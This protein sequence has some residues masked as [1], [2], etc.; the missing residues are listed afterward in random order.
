MASGSLNK[1]S[2]P[3]FGRPQ[4]LEIV[5]AHRALSSRVADITAPQRH[6][7]DVFCRPQGIQPNLTLPL[8]AIQRCLQYRDGAALQDCL[9]V[10]PEALMGVRVEPL[11]DT[12]T[13]PGCVCR[14]A[15][16][17][18]ALVSIDYNGDIV[19]ALEEGGGRK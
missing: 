13:D 4:P 3:L 17:E 2:K 11:S 6:R 1:G 19:R 7:E 12:L 10:L 14:C 15:A 18:H 5:A 9:D 16:I 8:P